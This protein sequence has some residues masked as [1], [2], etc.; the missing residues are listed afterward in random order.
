MI[1]SGSILSLY[2]LRKSKDI[3]FIKFEISEDVN[4]NEK[5][6]SKKIIDLIYNPDSFFYYKGFKFLT[7]DNLILMKKIRNEFKDRLD[8]KL[9]K[10]INNKNTL[11]K[12]INLIQ[13][14]RFIFM[15]LRKNIIFILFKFKLYFPLRYLYRIFK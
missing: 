10:N 2:G 11:F 6:Y 9:I 5:L 8:L 1:I 3:D 7:I 13:F 15:Y 12:I 4:N 14:S